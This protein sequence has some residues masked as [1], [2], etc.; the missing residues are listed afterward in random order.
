M[1]ETNVSNR[2][3]ENEVHGEYETLI[4]SYSSFL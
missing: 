1:S 3:K 2:T 4:T